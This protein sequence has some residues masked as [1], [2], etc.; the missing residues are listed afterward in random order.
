MRVCIYIFL[1]IKFLQIYYLLKHYIK[2][3]MI[4]KLFVRVIII[5]TTITSLQCGKPESQFT[6]WIGGSPREVDY[7]Q[8]LVNEFN[9]ET[10][11]NLI[12]VRQPTYTDQRR[13]GLVISL[14]AKQ[15]NPDL[16]LMDVVWIN[17]F[18]ESNW[19]EPLDK[20]VKRSNFPIKKFF[21]SILNSVDRYQNKLYALPVFMDVALLYYRKDLLSKYGF[22]GPPKTW[23]ELLDESL[24][25]QS[26]ERKKNSN[27]YGYAWQGAQYEGL[28]CDFLEFI[29]SN[30]GGIMH[31]GKIKL[32]TN[33]NAVALQFMQDLIHKYNISP[34]ST[35]TEMKEEEV[36]RAFQR[37]NAL[38]ER[39]WTYAWNLH[40]SKGS[41]VK[42][43]IGMTILPHFSGHESV[44]TLGG[45]HIGISK[46]SDEKEKAWKFIKFIT[47]FS[48]Q[49][50]LVLNV[51]WNPGRQDVYFDKDVL[52]Q[53]PHLKELYYV[54][55]HT[56]ARPTLP[57]YSQISDI[58]QRYVN[59]CLAGKIKPKIALD[60]MQKEVNQI[61][62]IYEEK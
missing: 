19:L 1:I 3:S 34:P 5:I 9:K 42:G 44:S 8:S 40:Q 41:K 17:Q 61:T 48:V 54:F 7:W 60:K 4:K 52:N 11:S 33:N 25:I 49:K 31:K 20:F 14:E 29:S 6:I 10:N 46:Y 12:L 2:A 39:N 37:G 21:P 51:G 18:A 57:Y 16:F 15:P 13:Q 45:W 32:N 28:V 55:K 30:G 23:N 24:K 59:D 56:V 47:S 58:I 22:D 53:L 27:F 26:K 38:F 62:K 36:R 35:Y 43:K 50:Q